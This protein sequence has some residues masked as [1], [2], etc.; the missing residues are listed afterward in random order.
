MGNEQI[1]ASDI[2]V[3]A[4]KLNLD[5]IP[6]SGPTT[7][8]ACCARPVL[9]GDIAV[10]DKDRFRQ[11]FTDGPSLA[12]RGSGAVCGAC[13]AV[14]N[15]GP[16]SKLQCHVITRNGAFPIG[17]DVN[18]AWFLMTPPEPPWVAVIS[19]TTLSHLIWRTPVTIDNN[20]MIVRLGPR[21]LRIR[22]NL[23]LQ[24]IADCQ[25]V[26]EALSAA[27][28]VQDGTKQRRAA[29]SYGPLRHPFASLNRDVDDPDFGRIR[30]DA[31]ALLVDPHSPT[32]L[33][34]SIERLHQLGMGELWALATLVK[35]RVE[36]PTEP[37]PLNFI[38]A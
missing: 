11:S 4:V 7:H 18:R 19:Q 1:F 31:Y 2:A 6:W 17:K 9:P 30:A 32:G 24:G 28:V 22:R 29:D 38:A 33:K 5:G 8:C 26:A 25:V 21:L 10:R 35:R 20:L 3:Q 37:E 23:L 14:M 13:S 34:Q 15:A 36:V 16:M 27:A 12:D